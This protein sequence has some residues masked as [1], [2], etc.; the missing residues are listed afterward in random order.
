MNEHEIDT[1]AALCT[2]V[3]AQAG[4]TPPEQIPSEALLRTALVELL[5]D[6]DPEVHELAEALWA[7][8][9]GGG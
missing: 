5:Q 7:S 4:V 3:I 9:Q 2:R 1:F 6:D 8:R